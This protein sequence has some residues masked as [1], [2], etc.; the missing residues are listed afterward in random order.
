MSVDWTRTYT[1]I[2]PNVQQIAQQ[3][4]VKL[5]KEKDIVCKDF[6]ALRCT[7]MQTT[8]AQAETEEQEFNEFFNYLNFTLE[9]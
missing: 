8:V 4:F 6:P 5:L 3:T 7:K 9:D 2:S 1:T